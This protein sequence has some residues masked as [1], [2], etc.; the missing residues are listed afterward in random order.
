TSALDASG[1]DSAFQRIL[2]EIYRLMSR[3]TIAA[4]NAAGPNLS[5]GETIALSSAR[6]DASSRSKSSCAG[7]CK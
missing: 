1:V 4:N 5:Q 2:T 3:K 6:D 7:S